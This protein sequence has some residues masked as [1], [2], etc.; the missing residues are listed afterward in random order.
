MGGELHI[1]A[2]GPWYGSRVDSRLLA[3]M[4]QF[5]CEAHAYR[6][7]PT[8]VLL[9]DGLLDL[10]RNRL[11]SR[12]IET[13][14]DWFI[15]VDSDISFDD[16]SRAIAESLW[17]HKRSD[18]A[19]VGAPAR[20]GNG[21]WNVLD[22]SE[23]PIGDERPTT[24]MDCGSIGFGWVAFRLGWYVQHWPKGAPFVQTLIY[25]DPR[26]KYGW[27][28]WGEDYGH[29]KAVRDL[30]GRIICDPSIR[31]KHHMVRPGHPAARDE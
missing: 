10:S 28:A 29:C 14:A 1:V 16:Q 30:G 6:L 7:R 21:R 25:P 12:A 15:S 18:I 17:R 22:L 23:Q 20:C 24:V 9:E 26:A 2:G 4:V 27:G 13:R 31:V 8:H 19:I 3:S 11:L 5:Y